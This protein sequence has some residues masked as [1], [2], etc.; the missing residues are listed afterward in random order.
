MTACRRF[1]FCSRRFSCRCAQLQLGIALRSYIISYLAFCSNLKGIAILLWFV[2]FTV[3][4]RFWLIPIAT[5]AI[6]H[7]AQCHTTPTVNQSMQPC[8]RALRPSSRPPLSSVVGRCDSH[9]DSQ[10]NADALHSVR[11]IPLALRIR[12]PTLPHLVC[13]DWSDCHVKH[14]Q[15]N[16]LLM[17][18][19]TML[20]N[21]GVSLIHC[22]PREFNANAY[23]LIELGP[24][25]RFS[26]SMHHRWQIRLCIV[27]CLN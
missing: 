8:K 3:R 22:H 5:A 14:S 24:V 26:F 27:H 10:C 25:Y 17:R 1:V 21:V 12:A 19:P 2:S 11:F 23:G 16:P 9:G 18:Q 4:C 7:F 20:L 15:A 13:N 6:F